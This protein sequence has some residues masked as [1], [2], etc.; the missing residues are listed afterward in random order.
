MQLSTFRAWR[1]SFEGYTTLIKADSECDLKARRHLVRSAID[2]SWQEFWTNGGLKV[3]SDDDIEDILNKM[4]AY[5]RKKRSPLLDRK[6]FCQRNQ[7]PGETIDEY[8]SK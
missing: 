2:T 3:S 5:L 4:Y 1:E 8:S 7:H 6:L